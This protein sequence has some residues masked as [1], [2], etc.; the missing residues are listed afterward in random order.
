MP[1]LPR[2]SE[3]MGRRAQEQHGD[4]QQDQRGADHP[5]QEDVAVRGIGL[6]TAGKHPQHRIVELHANLDHARIADRVDPERMLELFRKFLRQDV[7][8]N[9]EKRPRPW[10]G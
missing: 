9:R 7:V 6:A 5:E 1:V 4:G 3:D 2:P 8:K 10:R